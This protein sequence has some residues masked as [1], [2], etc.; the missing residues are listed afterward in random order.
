MKTTL[1]AALIVVGSM[2]VG[3]AD[4]PNVRLRPDGVVE[5]FSWEEFRF[6]PTG[7]RFV[8]VRP[9]RAA[10]LRIMLPAP[11]P[12]IPRFPTRI[13]RPSWAAPLKVLPKVR[14]PTRFEANL[15]ATD[16]RLYR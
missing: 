11:A 6:I 9:R 8:P 1:I 7:S 16:K 12:A 15:R 14:I 10:A 2:G 4:E 3:R 13:E 5:R